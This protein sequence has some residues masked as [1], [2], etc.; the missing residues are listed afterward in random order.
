MRI[1]NCCM[2][3]PILNNKS[4]CWLIC[5]IYRYLIPLMSLHHYDSETTVLK[6]KHIV[7]VRKETSEAIANFVTIYPV[8]IIQYSRDY[9]KILDLFLC[10]S[11]YELFSWIYLSFMVCLYT[12]FY[13]KKWNLLKCRL[14]SG[15]QCNS[16]TI[17]VNVGKQRVK[18]SVTL[19]DKKLI[20]HSRIVHLILRTCKFFFVCGWF[21]F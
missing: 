1:W 4:S 18:T 6:G 2:S 8:T 11:V 9:T 13:S 20:N 14:L 16:T 3:Y 15:C 10:S 5:T 21:Y 17:T 7:M 19:L 12:N